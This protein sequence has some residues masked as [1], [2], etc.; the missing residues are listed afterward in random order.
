MR[1]SL[2]DS[3]IGTGSSILLVPFSSISAAPTLILFSPT[4][5][6]CHVIEKNGPRSPSFLSF[7]LHD[8]KRSMSFVLIAKRNGSKQA[9]LGHMPSTGPITGAKQTRYYNWLSV[10]HVPTPVARWLGKKLW[11]AAPSQSH[12]QS[13]RRTFPQGCA[14]QTKTADVHPLVTANSW[15]R[16]FLSFASAICSCSSNAQ[17]VSTQLL[18]IFRKR[19][20]LGMSWANHFK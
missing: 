16:W 14:E 18:A 15:L 1:A 2:G 20:I 17:I 7:K 9:S 6:W 8:R 11:L 12:G 4:D 10:D 19:R 13:G 5:S 3:R